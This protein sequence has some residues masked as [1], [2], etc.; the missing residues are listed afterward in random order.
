M[1]ER[2]II[3]MVNEAYQKGFQDGFE[4]G[5]G[6]PSPYHQPVETHIKIDGKDFSKAVGKAIESN[7]NW[8]VQ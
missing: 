8:N 4:Y 3:E 1:D 7:A 6:K 2:E 5:T